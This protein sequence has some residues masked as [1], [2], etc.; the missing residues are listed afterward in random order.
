MKVFCIDLP[1]YDYFTCKAPIPT[2]GMIEEGKVYTVCDTEQINDVLFYCL[3]EL[4]CKD[5]WDSSCFV[6]L[7]EI[8]ETEFVREYKK[9]KV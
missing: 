6:P 7:S 8:D 1:G 5:Y 3:S 2:G 4:S 9:E